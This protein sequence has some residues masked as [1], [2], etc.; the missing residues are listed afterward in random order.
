MHV[1]LRM[2]LRVGS[3]VALLSAPIT[4]RSSASAQSVV[5]ANEIEFF[6]AVLAAF[7]ADSEPKLFVDPRAVAPDFGIVRP[8]PERFVRLSGEDSVARWSAST[9]QAKLGDAVKASQCAGW[10]L[11]A[12]D[13]SLG[14][15]CP[16]SL[17]RTIVVAL[18]REGGARFPS[19]YPAAM[20]LVS[21][22]L[23][24]RAVRVLQVDAFA[25]GSAVTAIDFVF[26]LQSGHWRL[27]ARV[28]VF[29][30]E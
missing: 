26:G 30:Q 11:V 14:S 6:R 23:T 7:S 20:P 1:V 13:A 2:A 10:T 5:T 28:P 15:E 25:R 16:G 18:S 19:G 9:S 3:L 8:D 24:L 29:V 21:E 22:G 17:Q 4:A 12:V 27:L